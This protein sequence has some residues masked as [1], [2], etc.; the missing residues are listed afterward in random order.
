MFG[1]S[2]NYGPGPSGTTNGTNQNQTDPYQQATY[3]QQL[4]L[5]QP[6][7]VYPQQVYNVLPPQNGSQQI[8]AEHFVFEESLS[9]HL[10]MG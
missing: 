3:G 8:L 5:Q 9:S 4:F 7:Q 6:L 10:H 2:L 1:S